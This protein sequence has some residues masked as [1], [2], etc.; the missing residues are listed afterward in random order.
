L[1]SKSV[2]LLVGQSL[3]GCT[4]IARSRM[5]RSVGALLLRLFLF[6]FF[7]NSLYGLELGGLVSAGSWRKAT[8]DFGG[9]DAP[10]VVFVLMHG[11]AKLYDLL[12]RLRL[13]GCGWQRT[14][15]CVSKP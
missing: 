7:F 12:C 13:A 4:R 11:V 14:T 6:F 15:S 5:G 1:S 2:A 3:I 9:D 10:T 8:S